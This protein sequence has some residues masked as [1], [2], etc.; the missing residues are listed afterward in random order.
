MVVYLLLIMRQKKRKTKAWKEFRLGRN[1]GLKGEPKQRI[2][3]V[4]EGEK[5]EPNYF[6]AFKVTSATVVVIGLGT[7]TVKLVSFALLLKE[8]ALKKEIPYDQVWCVFDRDSFSKTDFN[9]ALL[10][11]QQN[12]ID[13]AYSNEAFEVWYLL[14]FSYFQVGVKR[15]LYIQKLTKCLK[16]EYKKNSKTMYDDLL[17]YQKN[18]IKYAKKLLNSYGNHNP[19]KNNPSTTV[20]KLVEELNKNL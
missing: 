17:I 3:I 12:G 15:N 2:L 10:L 14:H 8:K 16:K 7:N 19:E 6:K 1:T 18:A 9:K 20:F 13:V 11:A 5:T 4:C